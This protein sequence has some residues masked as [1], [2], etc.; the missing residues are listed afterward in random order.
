MRIRI[1]R[2]IRIALIE[3]LKD[4]YLDTLKIP[5]LYGEK[6]NVFYDF[7]VESGTIDENGDDSTVNKN[8][9]NIREK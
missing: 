1:N 4:G 6:R 9:Y 2:E 5:E 7:L 8:T 3:A